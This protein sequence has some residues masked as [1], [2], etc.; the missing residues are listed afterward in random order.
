M[1]R[2]C[3]TDARTSRGPRSGRPRRRVPP[4]FPPPPP[5]EPLT[6][7]L[8]AAGLYA[9][10]A[11]AGLTAR[12]RREGRKLVERAAEAVCAGGYGGAGFDEV[13]RDRVESVLGDLWRVEE[14]ADNREPGHW[15]FIG[16]AGPGGVVL[17]EGYH[18]YAAPAGA[19]LGPDS[20]Y[21]TPEAL[22]AEA[23]ADL[24]A[25]M[26]ELAKVKPAVLPALRCLGKG[27]FQVGDDKAFTLTA[28]E[29][30]VMESFIGV[31]VMNESALRDRSGQ[32]C[33]AS[34]LRRLKTKKKINGRAGY[35]SAYIH[36]PGEKSTEGYRA[37]AVDARPQTQPTRPQ[38]R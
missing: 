21:K 6:F 23:D 3:K 31:P 27:M 9:A 13:V 8:A 14:A 24:E 30:N 4:A 35:L 10:R 34:I 15:A 5:A 29:R 32:A 12:E 26:A 22:R 11:R 2:S 17:S 28:P 37:E 18:I 7:F 1:T 38:A 20:S 36:L 19:D 16:S 33:A 25:H